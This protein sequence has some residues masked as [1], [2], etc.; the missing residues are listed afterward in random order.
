[1]GTARTKFLSRF[2][3]NLTL[4][5]RE[6]ACLR[7]CEVTMGEAEKRRV[8]GGLGRDLRRCLVTEVLQG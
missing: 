2:S 6:L 4:S 1:M 3:S 8:K 5:E 7:N